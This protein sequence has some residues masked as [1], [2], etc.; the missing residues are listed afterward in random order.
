[1]VLVGFGYYS[2]LSYFNVTRILFM[3]GKV[4]GKGIIVHLKILPRDLTVMNDLSGSH[5]F[6]LIEYECCKAERI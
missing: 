6:S 1:M 4:Q 3:H 2:R 5:A